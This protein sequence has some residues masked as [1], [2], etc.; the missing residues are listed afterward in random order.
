M[1]WW[2]K[3]KKV[4]DFVSPLQEKKEVVGESMKELLDG[5]LLAD[6]VLRK[7]MGFILF[8]TALGIVYIA[9]GYSTEKLYMQKVNLEKEL[10]DLRFESVTTASELMRLSVPSEVERRVH[11]AGLDLVQNRVPAVKLYTD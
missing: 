6:T 8:L 10:S 11:Q 9:N 7:N 4:K 3:G 1:N 5:R 2:F